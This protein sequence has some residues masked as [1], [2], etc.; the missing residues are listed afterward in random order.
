VRIR[1]SLAGEYRAE[2]L[3]AATVIEDVQYATSEQPT[4]DMSVKPMP[5]VEGFDAWRRGS[6]WVRWLLVCGSSLALCL[7]LS[8][9]LNVSL[10]IAN[11]PAVF[12]DYAV[13]RNVGYGPEPAHLLD[14]YRPAQEPA[15]GNVRPIVLFWHG[16]GWVSGSKSQYRF[17]AEALVSRGYIA[18]LPAYRLGEF[19][20]FIEDAAQ[21][22]AW[23]QRH[24]VEVGG[25]PARIFLM[26]HSAG[27]HIASLLTYDE[28]YLQAAG[29]G[30]AWVRGFIGLSGPYDFLP[31]R[32]EYVREVFGPADERAA[33]TVGFI[34]GQEPPALLLHGLDDHVVWPT[35]SKSLALFIRGHGGRVQEQYYAGVTHGGIVANLTRY[36]RNRRPVLD[37]IDAFIQAQSRTENIVTRTP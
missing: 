24:A 14:I 29:G 21:A 25:D 16:G 10:A 26:G 13:A 7:A 36:L 11:A 9:C 30:A 22:V 12:G 37:D 23:V 5:V 8:G 34:D 35:N 27:A 28:H 19:P 17:V 6:P 1:D 18:V 15:A 32:E 31:I 2:Q 3:P 20:G 4:I 33:Q